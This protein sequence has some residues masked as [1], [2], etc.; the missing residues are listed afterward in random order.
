MQI[1]HADL[2]AFT[3]EKKDYPAFLKDSLIRIGFNFPIT[4]ICDDNQLIVVD[5]HKRLS[6]LADVRLEDPSH[7]RCAK[8][9]YVLKHSRTKDAQHIRNHH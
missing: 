6:A 9:P 2:N 3:Y 7:P 5:G 8:I 4:V 1:L